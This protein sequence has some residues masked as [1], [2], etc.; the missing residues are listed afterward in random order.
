MTARSPA[1]CSTKN[2]LRTRGFYRRNGALTEN[3]FYLVEEGGIAV[4]RFVIHFQGG[5]ELFKEFALL[6]R[7]FRGRENAHMIVQVAFAAAARISETLALDAKNGAAL[8]GFR[9]FELFLTV[10]TRNLQLRAERCLR[11]AERNRAVKISAAPLEKGML[12][13]VEDN[14]KV[15]RRTAVRRRLSFTSHAD[16]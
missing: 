16:A 9:N 10:E 6:A 5:A 8:G 15:A 7:E 14:I 2:R 4:G 13:H 3:V 1:K 11:N 12:F